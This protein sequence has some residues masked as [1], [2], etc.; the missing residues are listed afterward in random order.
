MCPINY[1]FNG[2]LK[3][4]EDHQCFYVAKID[5]SKRLNKVQATDLIDIK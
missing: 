1:N 2:T 4:N 3:F 5:F